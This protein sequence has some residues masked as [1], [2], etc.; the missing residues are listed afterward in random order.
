[1]FT[2][3]PVPGVRCVTRSLPRNSKPVV[4]L[5][6][7][8]RLGGRVGPEI[9][10][11]Y[12]TEHPIEVDAVDDQGRI[13]MRRE[14]SI[15]VNDRSVVRDCRLWSDATDDAQF[16][17]IVSIVPAI[18]TRSVRRQYQTAIRTKDRETTRAAM[19]PRSLAESALL[20]GEMWPPLQ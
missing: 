9:I 1:M 10:L 16:L 6:F 2:N 4:Y 15:S 18:W 13:L 19:L 11:R 20:L 8:P 3:R 7:L 14:L 12:Q 5:G 17:H